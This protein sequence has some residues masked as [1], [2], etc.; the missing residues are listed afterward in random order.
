MENLGRVIYGLRGLKWVNK[1]MDV[2]FSN[3][4][5]NL[6]HDGWWGLGKMACAG[7]VFLSY[8]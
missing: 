2:Y 5:G 4:T 8:F 6:R 7:Q 3:V 1:R